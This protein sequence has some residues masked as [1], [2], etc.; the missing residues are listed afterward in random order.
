RVAY[1]LDDSRSRALVTTSDLAAR[2]P[3]TAAQRVLL[4]G[5]SAVIAARSDQNP[6]VPLAPDNLIYVIY[7]SGSTGRPKGVAMP[8]GVLS[9]LMMWQRGKSSAGVGTR[10][11]QFASL[12]FDASFHEMFSTWWTGGTLVGVSQETRRDPMALAA[13]LRAW[14]AGRLFLPFVA[15]QALAEAIELGAPPPLGLREIFT[16]GEQLRITRQIRAWLGA[17][18]IRLENHYGPTEGH[19]VTGHRLTGPAA[20]WPDLP[21]IGRPLSNVAIY[22]LDRSLAPVPQGA[23]GLLYIGGVQVVRGYLG[24]PELT[25][26]THVP[27]PFSAEPGARLYATGDQARFLEDGSIQF[28]G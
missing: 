20:G 24:R 16:S 21:P 23:L 27:D 6:R 13:V 12:S 4:D 2:L 18:G 11:I 3:A 15:L 26:A 10:T 14:N 9:N 22:L 1:M 7:T 5:D 25:A 17:S 28:F 8:H 19:V